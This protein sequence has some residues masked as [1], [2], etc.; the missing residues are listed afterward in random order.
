MHLF[1]S[2][3]AIS[4]QELAAALA[5]H[6]GPGDVILFSGE[7]GAGK[8]TFIQ[9]LCTA[10][11]VEADVLSPTFVLEHI[12]ETDSLDICHIDLYRLDNPMELEPVIYER[13]D[14]KALVLIEWAEKLPKGILTDCLKV[15]LNFGDLK[16]PDERKITFEALGQ[17][18]DER[19]TLLSN[20]AESSSKV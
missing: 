1:V 18:W 2:K 13:L 15:V 16:N 14:A 8:T 7:L 10:L 4:T 3:S 6:L 19:S 11:G 12:Y 17:A 5:P 20:L 9:G